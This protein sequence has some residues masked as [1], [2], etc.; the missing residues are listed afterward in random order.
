MNLERKAKSPPNYVQI[1][2]LEHRA[3]V[4]RAMVA[5]DADVV[6]VE[7]GEAVEGACYE[8]S[9]IIEMNVRDIR[10]SFGLRALLPSPYVS[11]ATGREG[12]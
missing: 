12:L 2:W 10:M 11:D 4:N 5:S 1:K 9:A 6:I 3:C 7:I 8:L